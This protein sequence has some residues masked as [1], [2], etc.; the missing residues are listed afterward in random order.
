MES[1]S[2][3]YGIIPC[4][5]QQ[6]LAGQPFHQA[7]LP[8]LLAPVFPGVDLLAHFLGAADGLFDLPGLAPGPMEGVQ[9]LAGAEQQEQPAQGQPQLL[10]DLAQALAPQQVKALLQQIQQD[11]QQ[12]L[13]QLHGLLLVLCPVLLQ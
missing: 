6:H 12:F 11:P 7:L 1:R 13:Q 3:H 10:G 9:A 4:S 5:A 2:F 8:G